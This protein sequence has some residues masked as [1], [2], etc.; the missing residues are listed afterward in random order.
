MEEKIQL[1]T[2]IGEIQNGIMRDI[3]TEE[4][5]IKEG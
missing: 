5:R 1:E 4:E 2:L 3:Y